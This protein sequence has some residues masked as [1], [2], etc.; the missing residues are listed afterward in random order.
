MGDKRK[1]KRKFDEELKKS[2]VKLYESGKSQNALAKEY[3][4]AL[5]SVT[6]WVKQ[7]S[8]VKIDDNTILTARQFKQLQK[9]NLQEV[10]IHSY[11][12]YD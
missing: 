3:G 7:Y 5:S 4:I 9:R 1:T 10:S 8:E 12:F 2:I 11:S 6:R